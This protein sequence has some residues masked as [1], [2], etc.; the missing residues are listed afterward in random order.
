LQEL[1]EADRGRF[2]AALAPELTPGR[3]IPQS[4]RALLI[5]SKIDPGRVAGVPS[6]AGCGRITGHADK[7]PVR[8]QRGRK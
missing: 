1:F 3:P 2:P 6:A 4:E 8:I 5:P 7:V